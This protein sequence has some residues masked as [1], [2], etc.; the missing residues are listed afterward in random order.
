[1]Q[2]VPGT[3]RRMTHK[4]VH[5]TTRILTFCLLA[6]VAGVLAFGSTSA[7]AATESVRNSTPINL[8]G[9]GTASPNPSTINMPAMEGV[10]TGV[11]VTFHDFTHGSGH[12]VFALLVSPDGKKSILMTGSC[13]YVSQPSTLLIFSDTAPRDMPVTG[14]CDK[15]VYRPTEHFPDEY[16]NFGSGVPDGPN[17]PNLNNFLGSPAQGAWKLYIKGYGGTSSGKINGGWSLTLQTAVP[18]AIVPAPGG[19][20]SG[21]ASVWPLTRTVSGLGDRVITDVD[22]SVRGVFHQN[23]ADLEM[24]LYGPRG[25]SAVLMSDVC[26]GNALYEG[27]T[28]D[29]EASL[30][31]SPERPCPTG[32]YR[33][34]GKAD[35]GFPG[36]GGPLPGVQTAL[37]DFD[38]TDPDGQWQLY[39]FDDHPYDDKA[40]LFL[41]RFN[42]QIETR[43]KATLEFADPTL[44]VEEGGSTE[45]T[46]RRTGPTGAQL[47]AASAHVITD[48]GTAGTE[49]FEY[50]T[51]RVEFA[52]GET[53]KK[54][55]VKALADQVSDPGETFKLRLHLVQG[56]A[57]AT[58]S[59]QATVAISEPAVGDPGD[60]GGPSDPSGGGQDPLPDLPPV[61]LVAPQISGLKVA[62]ARFGVSRRRTA[63]VARV[64]RGTKI[65]YSLSEAATVQ[66]RF[67]RAVARSGS[68]RRWV[69]AGALRR[70]GLAGANRVAFSGR[71]GRRA[72]RPGRYRLIVTATD[73]AGNRSSAKPLPLR[74]LR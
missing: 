31:M 41:E 8:P 39:V 4:R 33:P 3:L 54:V 67:Q 27:W 29:D 35:Q 16:V 62:P 65:R 10:V 69:K 57:N 68:R 24:T 19:G 6:A 5:R 2:L 71:I 74:V 60:P 44:E 49:D 25:Q 23:A 7:S 55:S 73:A 45:V 56:D 53:E 37:S 38:L 59:P 43:P 40:G 47:G 52:P 66:L 22:V 42:L 28:F 17:T 50:A 26:S 21:K 18:D 72:L 32:R 63:A 58:G 36:G 11:T 34:V 1:M 13:G 61:D 20:S 15:I 51:P 14:P 9:L 70:T 12:S 46:V 30:F 64:R 48:A